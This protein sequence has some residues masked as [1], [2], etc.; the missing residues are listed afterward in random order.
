MISWAYVVDLYGRSNL[1]ITCPGYIRMAVKRLV[2]AC[3][4][5][6]SKARLSLENLIRILIEQNYLGNKNFHKIVSVDQ[7]G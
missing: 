2:S 4:Q 6:W 1:C 7:V 3:W 5:G